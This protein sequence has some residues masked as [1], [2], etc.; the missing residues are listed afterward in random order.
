MLE[1]LI[2]VY[3]LIAFCSFLDLI[4]IPLKLK[5][6][7]YVF[8]GF[9][10]IFISGLRY[11]D[12]DYFNYI[13]G[14]NQAPL[15]DSEFMQMEIGYRY[16][17]Y[18]LKIFGFS[19]EAFIFIFSILSVTIAFIFF[20]KYTPFVFLA[21]LIYFS[22][23]FL[24]RDMLQIRSALS[25]GIVMFSIPY[26]EQRSLKKAI[27]IISIAGLFHFLSYFFVLVYFL[28]PFLTKKRAIYIVLLGFLLGMVINLTFFEYLFK[29]TKINIL[30]WYLHGNELYKK[31]L[32]LLNPVLLK[33]LIILLIVILN[34]DLLEVKVPYLK[35]LLT[36]YVVAC[37]WLSAFNDFSIFAARISTLFSNVEHILIPSLLFLKGKEIYFLGILAYTYVAFYVKWEDLELL[38]FVFNT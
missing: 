12:R 13:N 7:I 27:I 14:Y 4:L 33:Q 25:I 8:L 2:L 22:H 11:G 38:K 34:Y 1:S 32:G 10:L 9:I 6:V 36:S 20:R 35:V 31:S 28:Y 17:A 29:L 5:K 26:I 18:L 19:A 30:H 24:L 16:L 23:V 15:W 21:V 3:L 37:F